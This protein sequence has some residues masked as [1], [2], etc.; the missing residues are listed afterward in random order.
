MVPRAARRPPAKED[1]SL[2][3]E[4]AL[5]EGARVPTGRAAREDMTDSPS[6]MLRFLPHRKGKVRRRAQRSRVGRCARCLR[7]VEAAAHQP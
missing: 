7:A 6:T 2:R 4:G 1:G 5:D 3:K